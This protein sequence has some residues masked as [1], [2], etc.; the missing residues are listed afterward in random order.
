MRDI[1][2][3]AV[4]SRSMRPP[5]SFRARLGLIAGAAFALRAVWALAVA[6]ESLN[7]QGDARFFHL[8]ANLLVD[9]H[10]FIAP[11]PFA[12]SGVEL[13]TSEH[14]PGWPALLAAFS[15]FG[16]RSYTVHELVGCAVGAGIVVCAGLLGRRV[17]GPRA[18]LIAA[19]IA[20]LYPVY[21][22]LDGSLMSEPPYALGVAACM[23]LAFRVAELPARRNAALL[24]L[25]IG[26]TVLVRGEALG[27]LVVLAVPAVLAAPVR[28]LARLA[29]VWVVA[30]AVIAP[31]CLRNTATFDHP[32][33]VSSEDGPVIA[34]AN[35]DL[36]YH[37][38]DTGYWHSAC[39]GLRDEQNPALRSRALREQG[40]E[41]A[42]DHAGRVPAVLGVRVLR[43]LGVWQPRRLVFFAEGRDMPGR[44]VAM[45]CAWAVLALGSAG[46]WRLR[47]QRPDV[48]IL[49][50]PVVLALITTLIAFGYPRF[51]YAAD[52]SLIVFAAVLL[53][54]V[55]LRRAPAVGA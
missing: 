23:L 4:D 21:V 14:P 40:L 39:V 12:T 8:T 10:G 19:A 45:V 41:Y 17:G 15:A 55:R 3:G 28:R 7:H 35:C 37:G 18:G 50:A 49:L 22:A 26:L 43:T 32:M 34:G 38:R 51:R 11:L 2:H 47:R 1:L 25:G 5:G 20:A 46:A 52:V 53:A 27:L 24:G 29:L 30:L 31:W 44:T 9:G 54:N 16:G 6:P 48:A 42:R 36:T 13:P 33:L